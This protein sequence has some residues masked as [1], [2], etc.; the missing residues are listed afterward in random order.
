MMMMRE[1]WEEAKKY[2]EEP[3]YQYVGLR[4]E[5]KNREIGEICGRSKH[6]TDRVDDREY[7]E[8][9]TEDYDNMYELDGTSAWNLD[10]AH[11]DYQYGNSDC[12]YYETAHC[13]VIAGYS[14]TNTDDDLD[15]GEIVIRDAVV[16]GKIF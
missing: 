11:N 14:K 5:D 1:V 12:D 16:I 6:N 7:P 3:E 13:Y 10:D 15:D 8:Y 4:F 2:C 9:G